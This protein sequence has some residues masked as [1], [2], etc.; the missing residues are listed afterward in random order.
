MTDG[1]KD[2]PTAVALFKPC[3]SVGFDGVPD[4]NAAGILAGPGR[5]TTTCAYLVQDV[6]FLYLINFSYI[7]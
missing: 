3:K 5:A 2:G 1:S 7:S 4:V 6:H